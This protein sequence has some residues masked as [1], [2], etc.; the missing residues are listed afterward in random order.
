MGVLTAEQRQRIR[1]AKDAAARLTIATVPRL[2]TG[3]CVGCGCDHKEW[4]LGCSTCSERHRAYDKRRYYPHGIRWYKE[5]REA[6]RQF[7]LDK[8]RKSGRARYA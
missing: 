8:R 4:S 6:H 3:G 2:S 7:Y 5:Q 1:E